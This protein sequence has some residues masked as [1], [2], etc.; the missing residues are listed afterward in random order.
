[1]LSTGDAPSV[2]NWKSQSSLEILTQLA[3]EA[4]IS[5]NWEI[6][7]K[8]N[9]KI[10]TFDKSNTEALNRLARSL[11]CCGNYTKAQKT[12]K[13]VLELDPY[14]IIAKKNLEK[15]VKTPSLNTNGKLKTNGHTHLNGNGTIQQNLSTV[16][17]FE[18]GKTKTINLLNLAQPTTLASLNCGDSLDIVP[19]KHSIVI[20]DKDGTYLGALPDDLSHRLIS[21][22]E[23][24]NK[25]EAFVKFAT[26]KSLTIFIREVERSVKYTN[27]PSFQEPRTAEEEKQM[28]A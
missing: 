20:T 21:L 9:E 6:A 14:N 16:F 15:L 28:F 4:A 18:P 23:G 7:E 22:I 1:M 13:K 3:I 10:L 24:G 8:I 2:N 5:Q 25:Y 12:Y 19:K 11:V 17:L 26:T 27:Q